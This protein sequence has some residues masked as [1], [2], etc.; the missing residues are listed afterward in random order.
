MTATVQDIGASTQLQWSTAGSVVSIAF[1]NYFGVS[2]TKSLSGAAR[3]TID[4]CRTLLIWLFAI[5]V[6][7]EQFHGL[8][9]SPASHNS[10]PPG[11]KSY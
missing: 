8:Q 10:L 4:A 5:W 3:A 6:G 1:F 2:V 7:W 9:V 11:P